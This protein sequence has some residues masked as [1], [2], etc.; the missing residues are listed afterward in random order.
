MKQQ[1]EFG[2]NIYTKFSINLNQF[3]FLIKL[4]TKRDGSHARNQIFEVTIYYYFMYFHTPLSPKKVYRVKLVLTLQ[5]K[6]HRPT[7]SR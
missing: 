6:I 5:Y 2:E 3:Y 1:L 4:F 7:V